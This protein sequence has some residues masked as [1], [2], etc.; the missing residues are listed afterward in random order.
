MDSEEL[1]KQP[2]SGKSKAEESYE[3]NVEEG[4]EGDTMKKE[5]LEEIFKRICFGCFLELPEDNNAHFQ[6]SM[7]YD[8]LNYEIK[9]VRDDK[10]LKKRAKRSMKSGSTTVACRFVLA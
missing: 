5:N 6:M 7:V 8:L 2:Q 10:D 9:Y 3:N 4:G 1:S